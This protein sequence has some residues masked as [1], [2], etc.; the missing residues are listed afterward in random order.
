MSQGY[1]AKAL[2]ID[3]GQRHRKELEQARAIAALAGVEHRTADLTGVTQFM[4][5]SS[6]T[7]VDVDVPE[8]HYAD[9]N[10]KLTVVPNRNMLLLSVAAAWAIS[11]KADVVAYA[12]HGGDHSIYPDCRKEFIEQLGKAIEIADWH[13]TRLLAPFAEMTKGDIAKL[14]QALRAPMELTWSCYKGGERHCGR[15]GTCVERIEAFKLGGI[16]DPTVY[17]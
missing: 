16:K 17:A 6:Q 2:S 10:M 1:E 14:G 13:T 3:Y 15:C 12:A 5:G 9:E 8:G 4:Q 11:T 7:S